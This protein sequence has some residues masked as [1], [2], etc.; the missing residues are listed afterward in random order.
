M[1]DLKQ[2]ELKKETMNLLKGGMMVQRCH[3]G[4]D[5]MEVPFWGETYDELWEQFGQYCPGG[6]FACTPV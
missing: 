6:D 3:C 4:G 2:F 1:K 5:Y